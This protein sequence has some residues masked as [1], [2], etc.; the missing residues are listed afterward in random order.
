MRQGSL[1]SAWV[2][3]LEMVDR[4]AF[5]ELRQASLIPGTIYDGG[6]AGN[7]TDDPIQYLLPV[8]NAGGI[9][10][11]GP[12]DEPSMIVLYSTGQE[13]EWVDEIDVLGDG[14]VTYHGDNRTSQVGLTETAKRGNLLLHRFA[15]RDFQ[16]S[17]PLFVFSKAAA[18]GPS[19][20]VRYHGV[21]TPGSSGINKPDW[22]AAKWFDC[23]DGRF[24]NYV[25]VASLTGLQEL[26]RPEIDAITS[27]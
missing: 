21:A 9:R 8:G 17:I 5:S 22:L 16:P 15:K 19:R 25:L 13:T 6:A 2:R 18:G 7:I 10:W 26:S 11:K 20:S 12:V 24:Q 23:A 3:S 27:G 1:L 4:V 14:R